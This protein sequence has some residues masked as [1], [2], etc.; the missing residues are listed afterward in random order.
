M[1]F[2]VPD[3]KPEIGSLRPPLREHGRIA[4]GDVSV[5][6]ADN[7]VTQRIDRIVFGLQ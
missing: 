6:V 5:A 7:G 4:H 1:S 2:A 3:L